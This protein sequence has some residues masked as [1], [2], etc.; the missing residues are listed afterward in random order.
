MINYLRSLIFLYMG[1]VIF[2]QFCAQAQKFDRHKRGH[3]NH[4]AA[5]IASSRKI[6][7][8]FYS[9]KFTGRQYPFKSAYGRLPCCRFCLPQP[10]P[11]GGQ[12]DQ[13]TH[14]WSGATGEIGRQGGIS[15]EPFRRQFGFREDHPA[16]PIHR[17]EPRGYTSQS[18]PNQ[19][20]QRL[21]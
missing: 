15:S 5:T 20:R 16:S 12:I 17:I 1:D 8:A 11:F 4:A 19:E 10:V 14:T 2:G 7:K 9:I 3:Q 18:K 13:H 21:I 6:C